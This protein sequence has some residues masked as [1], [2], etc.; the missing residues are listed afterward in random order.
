MATAILL[1]SSKT[2]AFEPPTNLV[3]SGVVDV[4]RRG[5][6][7]C[8]VNDLIKLEESDNERFRPFETY[9]SDKD[10]HERSSGKCEKVQV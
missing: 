1:C 8:S 5:Q 10:I 6:P 3:S 2:G 4:E 7:T 9:I